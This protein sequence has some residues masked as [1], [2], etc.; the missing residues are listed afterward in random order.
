LF[1]CSY[2]LGV[3]LASARI[4]QLGLWATVAGALTALIERRFW[5]MTLAIVVA[6]VATMR[7]PEL[8]SIAG[9]IAS[10]CVTINVLWM[11]RRARPSER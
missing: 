2:A 7:A 5:P 9:A 6:L 10:L 11:W 1:F 4:L 3:D 8:R